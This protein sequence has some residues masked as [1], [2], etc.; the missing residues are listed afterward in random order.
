MIEEDYCEKHQLAHQ[1][2]G[3]GYHEC[4]E[5]DKEARDWAWDE[6]Q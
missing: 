5:C 4:V 3:E 6:A 2:L 1:N